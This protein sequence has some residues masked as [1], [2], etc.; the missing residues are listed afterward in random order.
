MNFKWSTVTDNGLVEEVVINSWEGF[1][2]SVLP[3]IIA[4][5]AIWGLAIWLIMLCMKG[6]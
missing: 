1:K 5:M 2:N 6:V 3:D 4:V